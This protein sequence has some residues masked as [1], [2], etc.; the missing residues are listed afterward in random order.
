MRPSTVRRLV[1]TV[2]L[3]AVVAG[4]AGYALLPAEDGAELR[5]ARAV[6]AASTGTGSIGTAPVGAALVEAVPGEPAPAGPARMRSALTAPV[7]EGG[8]PVFAPV[9]A[10]D[11]TPAPGPTPGSGTARGISPSWP[12]EMP[13]A[14]AEAVDVSMLP[15]SGAWEIH[16]GGSYLDFEVT[17]R[18]TTRQ[19]Y[20]EVVPV[21]RVLPYDYPAVLARPGRTAMGMLDRKDLDEWREVK[22]DQP[23]VGS[24]S[25]PG[26]F[27]LDPGESRTVRYRLTLSVGSPSGRLPVQA[28]GWIGR[29]AKAV[30]AGGAKAQVNVKV[31]QPVQFSMTK[32][33]DGT[34]GR[35]PSEVQVELANLDGFAQH[36]VTPAL[37]VTDRGTWNGKHDLSPADLIAEVL[38]DGEWLR[39]QGSVDE[40]G[41]VR[42]DTT[43]L[44]R[45]LGPGESVVYEFRLNVPSGWMPEAVVLM[46]AGA[47]VDGRALPD[48]A[49]IVPLLR[50]GW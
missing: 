1:R 37:T 2:P 5:P 35:L 27:A 43:G 6:G 19:R 23:G 17:W 4:A 15:L 30:R 29:S 39:L 13:G 49:A 24:G 36:T 31:D 45:V 38:A 28:E 11:R 40:Q 47:G 32:P 26:A 48:R 44:T 3:A 22:L 42:L 18:N 25:Q 41:R 34:R 12:E 20:D 10:A 8:A 50:A 46:T 33:S 21:V 14:V 7:A 9:A 16:A